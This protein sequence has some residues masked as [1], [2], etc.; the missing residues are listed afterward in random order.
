MHPRPGIS[1]LEAVNHIL[2]LLLF[3][4]DQ[5]F[6]SDYVSFFLSFLIRLK[7]NLKVHVIIVYCTFS[8]K[9]FYKAEFV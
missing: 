2:Y 4:D 8:F 1:K 5:D 3:L 6:I 7:K 9:I